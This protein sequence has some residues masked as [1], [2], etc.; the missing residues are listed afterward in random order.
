MFLKRKHPRVPDSQSAARDRIFRNV[1][2]FY[3][4][5]Q[6]PTVFDS[7]YIIDAR[8]G[9]LLTQDELIFYHPHFDHKSCQR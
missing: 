9:D 2:T 1:C 4:S 3:E 8:C 7:L 6:V 5:R